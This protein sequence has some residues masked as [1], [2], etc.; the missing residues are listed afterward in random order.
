MERSDTGFNLVRSYWQVYHE[1][2]RNAMGMSGRIGRRIRRTNLHCVYVD[3]KNDIQEKDITI[4]G[5]YTN[6]TRARNKA[7]KVLGTENAMVDNITSTDAYYSMSL[8]T[9]I[10]NADT[11][12]IIEQKE[13]DNG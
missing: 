2:G 7:R 10:K 6:E 13:E 5:D 9:F 8:E 12:K 11:V 1:R 4:Y 3:E